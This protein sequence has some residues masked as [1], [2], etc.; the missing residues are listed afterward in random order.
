MGYKK[1][2]TP[3]IDALARE[4]V[5]FTNAF[6]VGPNTP[7]SFP[8]IL[9][10]TFPLDYQGVRKMERP[11][12]FMSEAFREQGYTTAAFHSNPFLSEYF[13]YNQGWDFFE[14]ITPSYDQGRLERF[15]GKKINIILSGLKDVF[16]DLLRKVTSNTFPQFFFWVLYLGIKIRGSK[17]SFKVK[18]EYINQTVREFI[19]SAEDK[20]FFVW[21]HYMD[22]H[23]PYLS[24]GRY[25][26]GDPLSYSEI[27]GRHLIVYVKQ[28]NL[29]KKPV[30]KFVEKNIEKSIDLY[31]Q[32]IEYVDEQIG[33]LLGFLKEK[34]I[35]QN[36]IV[37]LASDHGEEFMEHGEGCHHN[38]LYN[39]LLHV[40]LL[41]K[42]PES[43]SK[44]MGKKVSLINLAP[45]LCTLTGL[46]SSPSFKGKNLFEDTDPLVFHQA[47]SKA[48][49]G[50]EEKFALQRLN[51]CQM[52]CQSND[53]KYI[54]DYGVPKEE[55][56]NL[57]KDPEEQNDVSQSEPEI[58]SQMRKIVEDFKKNNPPLSLV[59]R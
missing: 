36:S 38:K 58:L 24:K 41:I 49:P 12:V 9:T 17:D 45:T 5:V 14:D 50:Q 42:T 21:I 13:G 30:K 43:D 11:R 53:W 47:A 6:S 31:D 32:Q 4:S 34:N 29:H 33:N 10:S 3:N 46:S 18:A 39:E 23:D 54:I 44:T 25:L 59:N 52:A 35:Y 15:K 20:P 1:N 51:Q 16:R 22:A 40:P 37:C 56:Y 7:Y 55:L 8:A 27:V 26:H 57:S 48:N 28:D 2:I 19:D